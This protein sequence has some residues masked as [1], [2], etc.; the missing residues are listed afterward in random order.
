MKNR[1]LTTETP[2]IKYSFFHATHILHKFRNKNSFDKQTFFFISNMLTC[3][4]CFRDSKKKE[5]F[6]DDDII[7]LFRSMACWNEISILVALELFCVFVCTHAEKFRTFEWDTLAI[8][9]C[10]FFFFFFCCSFGI[11]S[12]SQR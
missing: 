12:F 6:S 1:R 10:F 9:R 3:Y 4:L 2:K 5:I 8:V 11:E 7:T